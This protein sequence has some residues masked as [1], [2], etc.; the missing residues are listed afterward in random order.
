MNRSLLLSYPS[1]V[2]LSPF[3]QTLF[4]KA[5]IGAP[6]KRMVRQAVN[7]ILPK[8]KPNQTAVDGNE[9]NATH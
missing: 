8:A 9:G 5:S 4:S 6:Q 1:M 2:F 7:N 3:F